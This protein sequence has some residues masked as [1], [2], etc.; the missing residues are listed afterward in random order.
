[1]ILPFCQKLF[2][3]IFY[4]SWNLLSAKDWSKVSLLAEHILDRVSIRNTWEGGEGTIR[5][6]GLQWGSE[7]SSAVFLLP[8]CKNYPWTSSFWSSVKHSYYYSL[9]YSWKNS[10]MI[11]VQ[12]ILSSWGCVESSIWRRIDDMNGGD[13][14][15]TMGPYVP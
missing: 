12:R 6:T 14:G 11:P 2:F 1:M 7:L 9:S 5:K 8:S 10:S 4:P 15:C 13:W 3:H